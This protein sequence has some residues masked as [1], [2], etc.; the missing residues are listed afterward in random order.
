MRIAP[1]ST[2]FGRNQSRRPKLFFKNV[3]AVKI[4]FASTTKS[5]RMS[6]GRTNEPTKKFTGGPFATNLFVG[7]KIYTAATA[8]SGV[9]TAF[10]TTINGRKLNWRRP[11]CLCSID[12]VG[13]VTPC[14][15]FFKVKFK[16]KSKIKSKVKFKLNVN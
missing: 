15:G 12:L 14:Q 2:I 4:I 13:K 3:R 6:D 1:I 10:Y 5:R 7:Y 16:V 9:Y 8:V 11:I